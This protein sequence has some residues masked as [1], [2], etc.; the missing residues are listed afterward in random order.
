MSL[1]VFN[2][3]LILF[4]FISCAQNEIAIQS[5]PSEA[6]VSI[7]NIDGKIKNIGKTPLTLKPNEAFRSGSQYS[8]IQISKDNYNTETVVLTKSIMPMYYELS[9]NLERQMQDA[10]SVEANSRN[11]KVAQQIAQAN[12][13][14][15]NKRLFEAEQLM[16]KFILDYP[17]ISVG[18]NYL[19][20]IN[21]M[22]RD[23]KKALT[24]YERA[25][26]INPENIETRE[27]ISKLKT[28][29]N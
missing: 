18:H 10:K 21:F 24:H 17:H 19:G 28:M 4:L 5:L 13:F 16:T 14:I 3:F 26:Q 7:I 9:V 15:N 2:K 27:M 8:Q 11:E 23:F 12:N 25:L 29:I 22:K 20:N 1:F 6:Q